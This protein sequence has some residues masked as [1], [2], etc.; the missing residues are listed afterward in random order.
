MHLVQ[1]DAAIEESL[2]NDSACIDAMVRD[3]W[4]QVAAIVHQLVGRKPTAA[5]VSVG[6]LERNGYFVVDTVT[7]EIVGSCAF[8]RQPSADGTVEIAYPTY[9]DFEGSHR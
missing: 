6:A 9:P 7:R 3:G 8:K 4:S 2:A 5:P 1:L